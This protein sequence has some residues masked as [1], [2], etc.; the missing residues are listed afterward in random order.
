MLATALGRGN[1]LQPKWE[2]V[3][4]PGE[5]GSR[6]AFNKTEAA[7]ALGVSVDFF[8]D[9][10]SREVPCVRRGRRHL[11]PVSE[12]QRWLERSAER[13]VVTNGGSNGK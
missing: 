7:T 4:M 11:Y 5:A 3:D 2:E 12:I 9:H 10:V 8:D 6:L 1:Q 13:V